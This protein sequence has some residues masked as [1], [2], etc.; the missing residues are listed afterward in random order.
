MNRE[1]INKRNRSRFQ[2]PDVSILSMNCI[3]GVLAHDL[4][5]RFNSPTVNLYMRAEDF[6]RFCENLPYYLSIEKMV[7]C[8]DPELVGERNYPVAYLGDLVLYLVHY[9]SVEE[10]DRKWQERKTRVRMDNLVI[11]AT[12]RDG[13]TEELKDRFE[14]LPYRKAM[15]TKKPDPAHPS[16]VYIPGFELE[17]SLGLI[18]EPIGSWGKRAIDRFDWV[19]FLNGEQPSGHI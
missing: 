9:A 14:K 18:T 5:I 17:Q 4:G 19:A 2:N 6:I 15:F 3:G 16:C 1:R 7:P 10:A 11:L 8:T 12:D 13:M